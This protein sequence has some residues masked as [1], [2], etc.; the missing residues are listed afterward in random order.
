MK[1]KRRLFW[2]WIEFLIFFRIMKVCKCGDIFYYWKF[3]K[4]NTQLSCFAKSDDFDARLKNEKLC[5]ICQSIYY[6]EV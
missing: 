1:L 2:F 4:P 3:K 5:P 6:E